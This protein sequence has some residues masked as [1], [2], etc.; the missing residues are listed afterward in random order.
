MIT[1]IVAV[2]IIALIF[3]LY[4][5]KSVLKESMGTDKMKEISEAIQEGA[6]AFLN[7]QYKTLLPI[8]IVIIVLLALFTEF[9]IASAIAFAVGALFSTLAGY[10]G[11]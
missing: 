9:G 4:L 7:R 10:M 2:G 3:A 5:S 6:M 11:M 1:F 8:A